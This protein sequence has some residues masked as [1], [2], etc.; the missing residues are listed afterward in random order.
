MAY[1]R[2][3]LAEVPGVVGVCSAKALSRITSTAAGE[4][5]AVCASGFDMTQLPCLC[6]H[7]AFTVMLHCESLCMRRFPP[8]F[9]EDLLYVYEPLVQS[10]IESPKSGSAV[11]DPMQVPL[12]GRMSEVKCRENCRVFLRSRLVQ[13]F[14]S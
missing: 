9:S 3:M 12:V 2:E 4:R 7:S 14:R 10:I 1:V 8:Q 13:A 11:L 5:G 6:L